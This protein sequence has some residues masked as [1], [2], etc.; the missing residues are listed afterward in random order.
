MINHL[1]KKFLNTFYISFS[2]RIRIKTLYEVPFWPPF[3]I[4]WFIEKIRIIIKSKK[5]PLPLW[6]QLKVTWHGFQVRFLERAHISLARLSSTSDERRTS[7]RATLQKS[8]TVKFLECF[9]TKQKSTKNDIFGAPKILKK[10][11]PKSKSK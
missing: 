4:K 2:S 6:P 7:E 1:I 11:R 5:R 3:N 9:T 10:T 8:R